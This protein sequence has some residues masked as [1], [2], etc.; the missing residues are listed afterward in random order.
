[1]RRPSV[2]GAAKQNDLR[3]AVHCSHRQSPFERESLVVTEVG[4]SRQRSGESVRHLDARVRGDELPHAIPVAPVESI[5]IEMQ[6]PLVRG[7]LRAR[8]GLPPGQARELGTAAMEC[9]FDAADGGI[10]QLRDFFQRIIEDVL[11]EHASAL[12]GRKQQHKMLDRPAQ[13]RPGRIGRRDGIGPRR[14]GF[15]LLP[16]FPAPKEVDTPVVSDPEQP[17]RQRA[18]IVEGLELAIGLEERVLNDV[19][20]VRDRSG[21]ARAVPVQARSEVADR[22]EKRKVARLETTGGDGI[23]RRVHTNEYAASGVRDTDSGGAGSMIEPNCSSD[24]S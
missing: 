8:R 3:L 16:D 6:D 22:L 15:R 5:D 4:R 23:R 7:A 13:C 2:A 14:I 12:H 17:R 21:H 11:Q 20:A 1:M 10:D 24:R 19:L 18:L 9:G